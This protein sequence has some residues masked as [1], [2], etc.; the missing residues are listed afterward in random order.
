MRKPILIFDGDC[1]FCRKWIAYWKTLTGDRVDYAPY[2][3][4]GGRFPDI[5][6]SRYEEAVQLVE[7]D[8][9]IRSGASAVFSALAARPGLGWI[10]GLYKR[11]PGVAALTE[12]AYRVVARNRVFFSRLTRFF[13]GE[14]VEPA[15][16]GLTRWVYLKG[17]GVTYLVAFVSFWVQASGL[18]GPQ[19]I[20]P[21]GWSDA[22]LHLLCGAGAAASLLLVAGVFP[23]LATIAAWVLYWYVMQ[24]GQ[25]FLGFQWDALMLEM[26]FFSIFLTLGRRAPSRLAVWILRWLLFRVVFYS[27]YVKLASHDPNWR[28][29][30]ALMYHFE[31]QPLP[32]WIGW[33]FHQLPLWALKFCAVG[34]FIGELGIPFLYYFPRRPRIFA[35]F[36]T[37][38]LQFLIDA[39]GNYGF[40]GWQVVALSLLLLDDE[41]YERFVPRLARMMHPP[42]EP[43]L[44]RISAIAG[45]TLVIA[46]AA[47]VALT[48]IYPVSQ[49][50]AW[51]APLNSINSY[52]VFAVMTTRRDELIFEGSNDGETWQ[53]YELKWKPGDLSRRPAFV[54]P[55]MPRLDWQLWFAGLGTLEQNPW[56][57]AVALRLLEG[58]KPVLALFEKNPFQE[59]PPRMVRVAYYQYHFTDIETH[60]KTGQW[61]TREPLGLYLPAVGLRHL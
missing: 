8:G 51:V 33:W 56:V 25:E 17:L 38:F 46:A 12:A 15:R 20:L 61:W 53:P 27:G 48:T 52:G 24:A 59:T 47:L 22:T 50:R 19:G 54:E 34:M 18:A 39:T 29:L 55:H 3:E 7:P 23:T 14:T 28:D 42:R 16:Y 32:T 36:A 41:F 6:K 1:G 11:V 45:P 4:V 57:E 35:F 9:T 30:T 26:G 43:W 31:T 40:F 37:L 10:H 60:R 5:P 49:V 21:I 13:W 44:P 2:Q 58:S